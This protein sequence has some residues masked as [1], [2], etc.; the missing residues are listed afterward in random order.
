MKFSISSSC[1]GVLKSVKS[2][3]P[4]IPLSFMTISAIYG[5]GSQQLWAILPVKMLNN[6]MWSF[7]VIFDVIPEILQLI[8]NFPHL[9]NNRWLG[10]L[11]WLMNEITTS[12]LIRFAILYFFGMEK[13]K[14]NQ[15]QECKIVIDNYAIAT[16]T[17]KFK[18][19]IQFA[20]PF[21]WYKSIEMT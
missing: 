17:F 19:K 12:K 3:N 10:K 7:R 15:I 13:T 21:H 9:S 14:M 5:T 1:A 18:F 11:F 4:G 20:V 6:G 16:F 2:I 8:S